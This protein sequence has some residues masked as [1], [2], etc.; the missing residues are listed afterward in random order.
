[1]VPTKQ[2]RTR[3]Q[4][5]YLYS[6]RQHVQSIMCCV[7][8]GGSRVML[9]VNSRRMADVSVMRWQGGAERIRANDVFHVSSLVKN[10][11]RNMVMYV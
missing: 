3:K 6:N 9:V 5:K 8:K 1:M 4:N 2:N 11:K 7:V 10:P